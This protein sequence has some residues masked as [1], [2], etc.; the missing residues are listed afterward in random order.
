MGYILYIT[1]ITFGELSSGSSVRPQKMLDAFKEIGLNVLLLSGSQAYK[2]KE[3]RLAQINNIYIEIKKEKPLF[4]YI[5]SPSDPIIFK[6]DRQLIKT[7]HDIGIKIGYFYRDAYYKVGRDYIFGGHHLSLKKY[8]RYIY[9]KA[10]FERDDRLIKKNIDLVYFPTLLMAEYFNFKQFDAL[11]PAGELIN[12]TGTDY[13][14]NLIYVGAVSEP[15]GANLMFKALD[16]INQKHNI[17]LI[18]VCRK[19][20]VINI[21]ERFKEK[22]WLKIVHATGTELGKYYKQ[23][24]LALLPKLPNKYNDFA[25]SVKI[26]EYMSYGLP[27]IAVKTLELSRFFDKFQIGKISEASVTEYANE[28]INL[29]FDEEQYQKYRLNVSNALL[30]DNLWIHRA[31]KIRADLSK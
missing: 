18:L 16:F 4:C 20:D 30:N 6:E 29:Y 11:P 26:F 24:R 2:N 23:A 13:H 17:N 14:E 31:E 9:Y 8:V 1:Y 7:I 28:I 27:I 12:I 22:Q 10:L 21:D 19:E 3:E 5:E 15:Y 25:M